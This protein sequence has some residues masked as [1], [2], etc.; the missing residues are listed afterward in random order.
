MLQKSTEFVYG[1][2]LTCILFDRNLIGMALPM[3]LDIVPMVQNS[4]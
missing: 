4:N 1:S 2:M 3:S